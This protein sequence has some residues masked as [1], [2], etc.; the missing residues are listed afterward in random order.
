MSGRK[1]HEAGSFS[2]GMVKPRRNMAKCVLPPKKCMWIAPIVQ[3]RPGGNLKMLLRGLGTLMPGNPGQ[4]LPSVSPSSPNRARFAHHRIDRKEVAV[5]RAVG[6]PASQLRRWRLQAAKALMAG[7]AISACR[8]S[9]TGQRVRLK[10]SS[11][12]AK[13]CVIDCWYFF[14]EECASQP[15]TR[16]SIAHA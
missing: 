9:A 12:Q 10:L 14:S 11:L 8:R 5:G 4:P 13:A 1:W 2:P 3:R 7:S 15:R 16:A 6:A